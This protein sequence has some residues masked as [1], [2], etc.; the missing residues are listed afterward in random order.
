MRIHITGRRTRVTLALLGGAS[1]LALITTSQLYLNWTAQGYE[2]DFLQLAGAKFIEWGMWAGF[3]PVIARIEQRFGFVARPLFPA[4]I[5]H[6]TAAVTF[7]AVLNGVLSVLTMRVD[8]AAAGA[9]GSVY[10]Q[11]A[12]AKVATALLIYSAVLTVAHMLRL[13]EERHREAAASAQLVADLAD[14]R[15]LNLRM[16]L[17]PHFLFNTLH[18]VAGLVREGDRATAVETLEELGEL[19]RRALRSVERQELPLREE[20][21][22][23][24]RYIRVQHLR[25][26][27]RLQVVIDVDEDATDALVP[28]LLLQPLVENAIRHGLDLDHDAG[29]VTITAQRTA[30][31]VV[32]A[33]Q[34]NGSGLDPLKLQ[35]GIGLGTTRRRLEHLHRSEAALVVSSEKSGGTRI[36]VRLPYR[37]GLTVQRER[38]YIHG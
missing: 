31:A 20:I 26:G 12:E 23:L 14:A 35:E 17:H 11:R 25:F 5:T 33:V 9:F 13:R 3:V 18:T 16:Q 24:E 28:T 22:F 7:F 29:C 6:M 32:I 34:D 15:L 21:E 37:V 4:L 8:Q 1:T 2:A 10:W 19:L 36:T 27:D 30:G 38:E